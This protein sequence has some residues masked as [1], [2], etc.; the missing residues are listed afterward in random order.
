MGFFS[1]VVQLFGHGFR[2]EIPA[3]SSLFCVHTRSDSIFK[4]AIVLYAIS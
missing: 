4:V 3:K 2:L 1:F